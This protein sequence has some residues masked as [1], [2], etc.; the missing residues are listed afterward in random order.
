MNNIQRLHGKSFK[1]LSWDDVRSLYKSYSRSNHEHD[2]ERAILLRDLER[3]E[4]WK[5]RGRY[6]SEAVWRAAKE[7]TWDQVVR[8]TLNESVV[9]VHNTIQMLT[10]FGESHYKRYGRTVLLKV[11]KRVGTPVPPSFLTALSTMM[12]A[13]G[14]VSVKGASELL[15]EFYPKEGQRNRVTREDLLAS[16]ERLREANK[17]LKGRVVELEAI[18]KKCPKCSRGVKAELLHAVPKAA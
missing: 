12:K 2:L 6:G 13:R 10:V 17:Q 18:A 16:A 3:N 9:E 7:Q 14:R 4:P 15:D 1:E 11:A 5:D 8:D